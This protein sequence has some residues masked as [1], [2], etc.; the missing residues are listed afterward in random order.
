M[1]FVCPLKLNALVKQ[2]G[3][4]FSNLG[5]VLDK[6]TTIAGES[7]KTSDLLNILGGSSQEWP[8]LVLG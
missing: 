4:W 5:E 6:T 8:E 1:T 2:I 7:E 3:Q